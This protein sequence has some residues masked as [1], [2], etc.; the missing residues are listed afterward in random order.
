MGFTLNEAIYNMICS[1]LH[2]NSKHAPPWIRHKRTKGWKVLCE[3]N[4]LSTKSHLELED[5]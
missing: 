5:G 3:I 4:H 2:T 1:N